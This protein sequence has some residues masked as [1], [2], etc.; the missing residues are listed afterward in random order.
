MSA[1]YFLLIYALMYK[2]GTIITMSSNDNDDSVSIELLG[3]L[4][5]LPESEFHLLEDDVKGKAVKDVD[6]IKEKSKFKK[7]E[8]SEHLELTKV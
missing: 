3:D 6:L 8:P 2:N 1:Y 7:L 4:S 5:E